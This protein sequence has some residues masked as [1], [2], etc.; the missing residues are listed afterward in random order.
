M[1][2]EHMEV[3]RGKFAGLS[4]AR[5]EHDPVLAAPG[6]ITRSGGIPCRRPG[7]SGPGTERDAMPVRVDR[8]MMRGALRTLRESWQRVVVVEIV[9]KVLGFALGTAASAAVLAWVEV[10][11]GGGAVTNTDLVRFLTR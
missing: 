8:E 2:H 5:R 10:R 7:E 1:L 11:S 3:Q 6:S 9:F 4:R